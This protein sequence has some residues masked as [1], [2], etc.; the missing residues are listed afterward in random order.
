M[1]VLFLQLLQVFACVSLVEEPIHHLLDVRDTGGI[2]DLSQG[3]FVGGD[4]S[5]L[6]FLCGVYRHV[7]CR[8]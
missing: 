1:R 5:L 2:P 8:R 3:L 6:V 7:H 4:V